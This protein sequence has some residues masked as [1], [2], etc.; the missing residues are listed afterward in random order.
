MLFWYV[1]QN[2]LSKGLGSIVLSQ[3]TVSRGAS[4]SS[5]PRSTAWGRAPL[6]THKAIL[7]TEVYPIK[8]LCLNAKIRQEK[9]NTAYGIVSAA[10]QVN[11][12]NNFL[13]NQEK[14]PGCLRSLHCPLLTLTQKSY[15]KREPRTNLM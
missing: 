7:F 15:Y 1:L 10:L 11:R 13:S 9:G 8:D 14:S 5:F 6:L 4:A 2:S 12:D 3:L